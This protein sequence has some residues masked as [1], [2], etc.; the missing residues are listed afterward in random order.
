MYTLILS[1]VVRLLL[2]TTTSHTAYHKW[3]KDN[4]GSIVNIIVDM[5]TGFPGMA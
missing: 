2:N 3:M 5:L 4:G 1:C